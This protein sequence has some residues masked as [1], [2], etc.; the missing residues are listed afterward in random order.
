MTTAEAAAPTFIAN[1]HREEPWWV[2]DVPQIGTT[3][4]ERTE[5][6]EHMARDLVETVT[7]SSDVNIRVTFA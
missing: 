5:D 4:A 3:Q 2:I 1:V 7:G 6:I